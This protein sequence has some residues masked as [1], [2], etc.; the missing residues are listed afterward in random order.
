MIHGIIRYCYG[1]HLSASS[2]LLNKPIFCRT[3]VVG[4]CAWIQGGSGARLLLLLCLPL[5]FLCWGKG[6]FCSFCK[7]SDRE[8]SCL[9]ADDALTS[10]SISYPPCQR[11]NDDT[12]QVRTPACCE[13]NYL[14]ML[15]DGYDRIQIMTLHLQLHE[16]FFFSPLFLSVQVLTAFT[17]QSAHCWRQFQLQRN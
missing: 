17:Y 1:K 4:F 16:G 8:A 13:P 11:G 15:S 3:S 14:Q 12:A 6:S 7:C 2:I 9:S 5:L 10:L